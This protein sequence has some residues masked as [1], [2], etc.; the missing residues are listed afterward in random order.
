MLQNVHPIP[1][2]SRS[3]NKSEQ[4]YEQ[5][6]KEI[7]AIVF[8]ATK[9]HE[10][11]YAIYVESD[12]RPLESLFKKALSQK[13]PGIQRMILKVQKYDLHVIYKQGTELHIADTFSR[14]CISPKR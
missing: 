11:I 14:A 2:A 7:T 4:D 5:I 12:H 3:L 13:P 9:F 8:E 10:Y 6:E 1:Y